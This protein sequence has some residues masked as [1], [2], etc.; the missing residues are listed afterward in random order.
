MEFFYLFVF[1]VH[2][3][4]V[5]HVYMCA[6]MLCCFHCLTSTQQLYGGKECLFNSVIS[7]GRVWR[8][9]LESDAWSV[10]ILFHL[11][12]KWQTGVTLLVISKQNF[13]DDSAALDM[14]VAGD[15]VA[16]GVKVVTG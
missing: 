13:W 8:K 16:L 3:A 4:D 7:S 11:S 9:M 6:W 15:S 2:G 10:T 1:F 14:E 12:V 5:P